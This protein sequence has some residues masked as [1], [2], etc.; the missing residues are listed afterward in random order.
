MALYGS[1]AQT[2]KMIRGTPEIQLGTDFDS[3]FQG[4]QAAVS[5]IIER[6]TGRAF[7]GGAALPESRLIYAGP[8]TSLLLEV[9][10]RTITSIQRY[11]QWTGTAYTGG[12][13]LAGI[14]WIPDPVDVDGLILGARLAYGGAWGISDNYGRPATPIYITGTWSDQPAEAEAPADITYVANYVIAEIFKAEQASPAGFV[15]PDGTVTPIRNPWRNETVNQILDSYAV[16]KVP[17]F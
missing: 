11:G 14:D 6:K 5:R 12:I 9:P 13:T 1:N 4:I 2:Q 10:A 15:G 7:G 3:R 17:I 16:Q 8:Y